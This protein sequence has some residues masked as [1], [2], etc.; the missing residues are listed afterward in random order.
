[1]YIVFMFL[2]T[3]YMSTLTDVLINRRYNLLITAAK[4]LLLT[5]AAI[6]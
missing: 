2:I 5:K 1:M 3:K 4:I 6:L